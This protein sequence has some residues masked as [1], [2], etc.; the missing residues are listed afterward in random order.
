[1]KKTRVICGGICF[2]VLGVCLIL[3]VNK[4]EAANKTK[5]VQEDMLAY[6]MVLNNKKQFVSI[7]ENGQRFYWNEYFWRFQNM[8]TEYHADYFIIVDLFGRGDCWM[9]GIESWCR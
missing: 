2:A 1:M 7:A 9:V 5:E 8:C 3:P 6:W 4:K